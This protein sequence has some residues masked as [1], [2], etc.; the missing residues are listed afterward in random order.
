MCV[1]GC[2]RTRLCIGACV[3]ACKCVYEYVWVYVYYALRL[4][5]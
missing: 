1:F 4:F 2:V 5:Q 3:S